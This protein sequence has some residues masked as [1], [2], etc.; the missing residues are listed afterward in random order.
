MAVHRESQMFS[1]WQKNGATAGLLNIIQQSLGQVIVDHLDQ[2]ARN[3]FYAHPYP[4]IGLNAA[5][6]FAGLSGSTDIMTTDLV[7][8]VWLALHDRQK[9]YSAIAQGYVTGDEIICI[10]TAG[11]VHDLKREVGTGA[12]GLN[13]VDINKYTDEGRARLIRGE[14]GMYRGVRFVD[15]PMA[16]IWNAGDITVQTT[17]TAA[18]TPGSGAP[19]PATTLVEGTRKVGQPGATHSITVADTTGLTAGDMI[20]IHKLRHTGG[21][22]LAAYGAGTLNGPRIDDPMRQDVEIH[23]VVNGTT[24]TLKE[25]YMM[26]TDYGAGLETDLGGGVYGYV[27]KAVTVHSALFLTPGLSS[28]ALVAGVA[29][30]PVIYMP[31]AI[32]DYLSINRVTYDFWMKYQLWDA[33]AYH[34]AYLRG[35]N[36][37]IGK[38]IF[39]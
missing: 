13:F 24:L 23:S 2:L 9:P 1:Y 36:S 30:P 11:A 16:K 37:L 22:V 15:N 39:R 14:L 34:L 21:T 28:N 7:D 3:A 12:G 6:S 17:I 33:R 4:I 27:T 19:D 26:T 31:P 8:Q 5:S 10:T 35:S 20:T 18:V 38:S 29:Q 25:P 32:D